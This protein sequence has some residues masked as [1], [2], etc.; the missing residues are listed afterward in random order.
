MEKGA[1]GG[2]EQQQW[3]WWEGE[4]V[5]FRLNSNLPGL[6]LLHA[7]AKGTLSTWSGILTE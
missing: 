1:K 3:P 6:F 5:G 7:P 4:W 2:N